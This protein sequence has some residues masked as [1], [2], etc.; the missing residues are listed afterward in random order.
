M[1]ARSSRWAVL[2]DCLVLTGIPR[3]LRDVNRGAKEQRTTIRNSWDIQLSMY[4]LCSYAA[5]LCRVELHTLITFAAQ[6]LLV[7][8]L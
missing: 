3:C 5:H 8:V 1:L 2:F 6:N 4:E 7:L